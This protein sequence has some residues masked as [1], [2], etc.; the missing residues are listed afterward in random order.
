MKPVA[1]DISCSFVSNFD[2]GKRKGGFD[3]LGGKILDLIR[4][5]FPNTF[6]VDNVNPPVQKT[7]RYMSKIFRKIGIPARFPIFSKSRLDITAGLLHQRIPPQTDFIIFHG[8]TPW[9][10]YT[11]RHKYFTFTDCSFETYISNYHDRRQYSKKDSNRIIKA[12]EKFFANAE[13]VFL[14]SEWAISETKKHYH[15]SGD[16]FLNI[17]QGPSMEISVNAFS[18]NAPLNQFVF[19]GTDFLGKGGA[20]ICNAFKRFTRD[21]SDYKLIVIGQRPPEEFLAIPNIEFLGYVNKSTPEG[22]LQFEQIYQQSKALLL[23]TKKDIS[24]LVLIEA[25][26]HGCPSI[27]NGQGAIPEMI[28]EN[29]TGFLINTSEDECLSAMKLIAGMDEGMLLKLRRETR[30]HYQA[31]YDWSNIMKVIT[32]RM[33]QI[34]TVESYI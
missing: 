19:I 6:L 12:E 14:T 33:H 22:R 11:P 29:L 8:T 10:N 31:N 13:Q 21:H 20:E 9:I 30:D 16:N 17:R 27:A 23:L 7:D 25:G 4:V 2:L 24:P 26:L 5:E 32:K 1:G 3:G 18:G 34:T 28:V 15:L